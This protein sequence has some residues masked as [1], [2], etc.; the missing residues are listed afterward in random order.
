MVACGKEPETR[1]LDRRGGDPARLQ[2]AA[3]PPAPLAHELAPAERVDLL[4]E[5][6]F[7]VAGLRALER[8]GIHVGALGELLDG[9]HEVRSPR[10]DSTVDVGGPE[11][12][13]AAVDEEATRRRAVRHDARGAHAQAAVRVLLV[14]GHPP[15]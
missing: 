8:R 12:R 7:A 1:V 2:V 5:L 6:G 13:L 14:R 4:K 9:P 10:D 15:L 3:R 11:G